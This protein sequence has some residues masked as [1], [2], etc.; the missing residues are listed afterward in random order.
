MLN[1]F[2]FANW[3]APKNVKTLITKRVDV[4][5]K[6]FN[7]ALH[8]GDQQSNVY[9]NREILAKY[10]PNN[11]QWLNQTHT[12]LVLDLDQPYTTPPNF[13]AALTH[14][15]GKV[16]V[17][18]TADCLPIFIT[19]INAS[20]VG[21]IHAGW[22]GVETQIIANA[23]NLTKV[24]P[25]SILAYIGPSI[26]AKHFE[27]GMDVF[28]IF[29]KLNKNN[30]SFFS[31]KNNNKFECDLIGIAKL[32]LLNLGVIENNIYLSGQCTYCNNDLFYSYRKEKSTGRFASLIWLE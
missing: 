32:Q 16:C 25:K 2:L 13:D 21:A 22:R 20:F 4:D 3:N 30:T 24:A 14:T 27:V 28:D 23:I 12:N 18:M 1:N 9:H 11:P 15:I 29:T 19:D 31:L 5:N 26:C 8:V 6:P 17:V 7:L 10:L